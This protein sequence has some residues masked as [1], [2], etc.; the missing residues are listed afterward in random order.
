MMDV[1]HRTFV[2]T[3]KMCDM[4]S[5]PKVYLGDYVSVSVHLLEQVRHSGAGRC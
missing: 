2:P 4:K 3:H 1:Y 5:Q